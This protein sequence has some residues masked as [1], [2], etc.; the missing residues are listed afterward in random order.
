MRSTSTR[1]IGLSLH[2][3][4]YRHTVKSGLG[5]KLGRLLRDTAFSAKKH[6]S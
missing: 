3:I 6:I 2:L 4:T 5:R 1:E